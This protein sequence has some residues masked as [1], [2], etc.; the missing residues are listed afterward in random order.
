MKLMI[1]DSGGERFPGYFIRQAVEAITGRCGWAALASGYVTFDGYNER[2][3][4]T[5]LASS[6]V[7][8]GR[9]RVN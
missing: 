5:Y 6:S 4:G 8:W 1:G 2:W 7:P 3:F 9:S